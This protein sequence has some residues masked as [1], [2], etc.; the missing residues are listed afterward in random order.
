MPVPL[1]LKMILGN[2][3]LILRAAGAPKW[4]NIIGYTPAYLFSKLYS[5]I[6]KVTTFDPVVLAILDKA[7]HN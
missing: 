2:A 1:S 7:R 5:S 6:K 3:V 4:Q